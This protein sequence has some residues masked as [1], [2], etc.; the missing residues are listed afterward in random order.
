MSSTRRSPR[1][2]RRVTYAYGVL[3]VAAFVGL[4]GFGYS[5]QNGLFWQSHYMLNADVRDAAN[6]SP[7]AIVRMDGEIVGQV[8]TVD[9][10]RGIA[11]I[12]LQLNQSVRPLR[13]S[14]ELAL[15]AQNALGQYFVE[16]TPGQTGRLIPSGGTLP[17]TQSRPV[18]ELDQVLSM[19]DPKT[20]ARTQQLLGELGGS[21]LGRSGD[22]SETLASGARLLTDVRRVARP[23]NQPNRPV[24]TL[25][26]G[27]DRFARATDPVRWQLADG[28]APEAK[29]V[30][31]LQAERRSTLA[32][33]DAAP[34][35]LDAVSTELAPARTLLSQLGRLAVVARPLLRAAPAGLKGLGRMLPVAGPG[36]ASL[37]PALRQFDH[38]IPA[39]LDLL[40]ALQPSLK[41]AVQTLRN[42]T[43]TFQDLASRPCQFAQFLLN[44]GGPQGLV[45]FANGGGGFV[46]FKWVFH[47]LP[48][49]GASTPT[50]AP[51]VPYPS[52]S[53]C[54]GN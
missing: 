29:A 54:G 24:A 23:L 39:T 12:Q 9:V 28:F 38:A 37:T 19:L 20:R 8:L 27:L 35:A 18:V 41:P 14:T 25:I 53:D 4:I 1:A 16:L 33:L 13:S 5:A 46:R 32:A 31:P 51:A 47:D 45:T 34:G 43:L 44:W 49:A 21:V 30:A 10:H 40:R 42:A 48:L 3:V 36:L 22:I 11:R 6:L 50:A 2:Q 52:P 17:E 7:H 26:D 15:R